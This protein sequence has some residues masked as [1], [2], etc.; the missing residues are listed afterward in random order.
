MTRTKTDTPS[1]VAGSPP[2]ST[3]RDTFPAHAWQGKRRIYPEERSAGNSDPGYSA[4]EDEAE[5]TGAQIAESANTKLM[6]RA[7]IQVEHLDDLDSI[8]F[9]I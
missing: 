2:R 1:S 9:L 5:V 3:R 6:K 7:R 8:V 4:S